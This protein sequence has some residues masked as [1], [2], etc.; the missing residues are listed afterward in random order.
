MS[1]SK[2]QVEYPIFLEFTHH[3]KDDYWK[4]LYEDMAFGKFPSGAYIQKNYFCCYSKGKELSVELIPKNFTVFTQ[5]H[6]LL[7]D[8]LGIKSEKEKLLLKEELFQNQYVKDPKRLIKDVSLT[9]FII[10]KGEQYK[11]PDNLIRKIF[12]V[13]IIGFMFKTILLK[14]VVFQGNNIQEI[15]G[16]AFS[17]KTVRINKNILELK[18]PMDLEQQQHNSLS[19]NNNNL[20]SPHWQ[21]YLH[22]LSLFN[23]DDEYNNNLATTTTTTTTITKIPSDY[24]PLQPL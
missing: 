6:S 13:F 7:S 18:K 24:D 19:N 22:N 4:L 12:S 2:S 5:I 11:L 16:F 23:M 10:K 3:V 15:N 17:N 1:K 20:M 8:H 9:S 21:K 14:D